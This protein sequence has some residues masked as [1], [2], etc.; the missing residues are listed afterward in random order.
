[1]RIT[2]GSYRGRRIQCPPGIIRPAMDRMRESLFS[3]LGP[4]NGS[5]FLDLFT[6]SGLVGLEAASRGADPIVLVEM[7]RK[8]RPVIMKNIAIAEESVKLVMM[9]AERFI[10]RGQ[11]SFDIIYLDPPFPMPG[12]QKLIG[13]IS[14]SSLLNEGG[15][16]IIHHPGEEEWPETIGDLVCRDRR[17]Y[18][19]S[20]LRFFERSQ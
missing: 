4:L 6:G 5:S 11:G 14:K 10:Q 1:M 15:R 17:A 18:G 8:K 20:I 12:K 19:R 3:I 13:G 2:G 7:D 16:V 9:P